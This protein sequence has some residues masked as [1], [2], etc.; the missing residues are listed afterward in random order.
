MA[1]LDRLAGASLDGLF[2]ENKDAVE[3]LRARLGTEDA[4]E[5]DQAL[6]R[7]VI[8]ENGSI[9]E[10]ET[11]AKQGREHRKTYQRVLDMARKGEPL[12]QETKIRQHLCYGRWR[13][14]DPE[15]EKSLAPMLITRSGRCD[16]QA[17][18]QA[19]TVE[20]L[21]E[22][23]LWE[24]QVCFDET[25]KASQDAGKLVLMIGVNDLD[26]ASLV[27]GREKK[28]FEAVKIA[29]ETGACMFPLL[30]RKHVMVNAGMLIDALYRVVS[31][32]MPQRV[33]DK[34]AFM[35]CEEFFLAA[36]IPADKFP[37]FLG[38]S[39]PVPPESHL[40]KAIVSTSLW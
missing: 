40:N 32:F 19:V 33:L 9:D 21:V 36:Q 8:Q 28:F 10:A 18:M 27:V 30:T 39:C 11:K 16:G 29:S 5:T 25:T 13:Y 23:F 15:S 6:L 3:A 17:L 31:V 1:T 34:V 37:D 14:P 4:C 2:A 12:P 22:Y 7:F 35:T 26:G 24:R 20:E 38:G